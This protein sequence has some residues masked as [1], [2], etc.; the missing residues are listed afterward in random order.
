MMAAAMAA[1][2]GLNRDSDVL[3]LDSEA[4]RML[5]AHAAG[6]SHGTRSGSPPGAWVATTQMGSHVTCTP[7]PSLSTPLILT[8]SAMPACCPSHIRGEC[9]GLTMGA[10]RRLASDY[11]TANQCRLFNGKCRLFN[12]KC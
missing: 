5:A 7:S 12:G 4:A 10:A 8:L 6:A 11:S 9:D 2:E 3:C 1:V